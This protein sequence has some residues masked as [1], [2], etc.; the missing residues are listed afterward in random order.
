MRIVS[1]FRDYYD[2]VQSYGRDEG[3][4]VFVR[5]SSTIVGEKYGRATIDKSNNRFRNPT[6]SSIEKYVYPDTFEE[7]STVG[8]K[9]GCVSKYGNA[10]IGSGC[11]SIKVNVGYVFFTG[12]VYPYVNFSSLPDL[13]SVFCYT[14]D[15]Y[16]IASEKL[17]I[18]D[19]GF[20]FAFN[21][22]SPNRF[23]RVSSIFE[24]DLISIPEEFFIKNKISIMH[25][26]GEMEPS[27]EVN[28]NLGD[29]EFYKAMDAF[30]AYQDLSTWVNGKLSSPFNSMVD[31]DD[32]TKVMKHGFDFD[33]GFRKRPNRG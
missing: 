6:F 26:Y 30:S 14:E 28:P 18:R 5:E 23:K 13:K 17:G 25:L 15:Q 24:V 12:K 1:S 3:S 27:I 9:T 8:P 19:K 10:E 11:Y 22:G 4:E 31:I 2:S 29:L 33:Y 21:F 16:Y 32:K 20:S 7:Y